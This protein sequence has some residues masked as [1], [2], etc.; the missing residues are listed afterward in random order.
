MQQHF[1]I[2]TIACNWQRDIHTC[3]HMFWRVF[4]GFTEDHVHKTTCVSV[5]M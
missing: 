1:N 5:R 4:S 2:Q 3:Q